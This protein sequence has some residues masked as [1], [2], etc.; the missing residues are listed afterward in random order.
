M[1]TTGDQGFDHGKTRFFRREDLEEIAEMGRTKRRLL[2]VVWALAGLVVI[3]GLCLAL[4]WWS[5]WR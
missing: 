4:L 1:G 3:L 5:N 2:E